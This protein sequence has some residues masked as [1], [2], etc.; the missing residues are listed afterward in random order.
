[1]YNSNT[2]S[3]S[4]ILGVEVFFSEGHCSGALC[5][6]SANFPLELGDN[7]LVLSHVERHIQHILVDLR[8]SLL[9]IF[10]VQCGNK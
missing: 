5:L 7:V 8:V 3:N 2:E 1:M 4:L 6:Q 10:H 9:R